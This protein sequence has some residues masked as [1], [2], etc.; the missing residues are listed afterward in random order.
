MTIAVQ[1][2]ASEKTHAKPGIWKGD[3]LHGG[4][5]SSNRSRKIQPFIL[6][7]FLPYTGS[8]KNIRSGLT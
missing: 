8:E 7:G 5:A 4:Q 2:S 1:F 6:P 3:P